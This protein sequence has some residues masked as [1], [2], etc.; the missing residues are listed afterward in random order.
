[1]ETSLG[2]G[3]KPLYTLHS[4]LKGTH[5][6]SFFNIYLL[7]FFNI[8]LLYFFTIDLAPDTTIDLAPDTGTRAS[9]LISSHS[10]PP[11]FADSNR[12]VAFH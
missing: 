8:D 4:L 2:L 9:I 6:S 12:V 3:I 10:L 7:C 5:H 1:M 11:A